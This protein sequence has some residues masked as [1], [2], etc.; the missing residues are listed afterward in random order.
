MCPS[1]G[2]DLSMLGRYDEALENDLRL[3]PVY[4]RERRADHEHTL[5]LRHNIAI[6]LRCLGRFEKALAY[7]Q[8]TLEETPP[9]ARVQRRLHA[10]LPVRGGA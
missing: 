10:Y 5:K 6:S 8:Q 3:L 9:D 7:D 4:E 1:Y 2:R